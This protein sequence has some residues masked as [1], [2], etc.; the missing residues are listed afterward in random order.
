MIQNHVDLDY[1]M[2][3]VEFLVACPEGITRRIQ[4]SPEA[5]IHIETMDLGIVPG[6]PPAEVDPEEPECE[7]EG[8]DP[9][10]YGKYCSRC[11][12]EIVWEEIGLGEKG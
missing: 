8:C 1:S 4:C 3:E 6:N 7:R 5:V 9:D 12:S 10:T 2:D 11:G